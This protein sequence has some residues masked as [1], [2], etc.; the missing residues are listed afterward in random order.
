MQLANIRE[1]LLEAYKHY[2]VLLENELKNQQKKEKKEHHQN[3]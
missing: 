1:K 3:Q 2:S